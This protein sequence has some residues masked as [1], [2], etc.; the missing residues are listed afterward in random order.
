MK[1][2]TNVPI[3]DVRSFLE[4]GKF[5]GEATDPLQAMIRAG[6]IKTDE[7]RR[8]KVQVYAEAFVMTRRASK[9]VFPI[10]PEK[11]SKPLRLD[12]LL[13]IVSLD[14]ALERAKPRSAK[15]GGKRTA[16][17]KEKSAAK[18]VKKPAAAAPA[19]EGDEPASCVIG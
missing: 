12:Q 4:T 10:K 13:K 18:R 16:A 2:S 14:E 11:L 1:G 5:R 17:S 9:G 6:M 3:D 7:D 19:E 15:K 8:A